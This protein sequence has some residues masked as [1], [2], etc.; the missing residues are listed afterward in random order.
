MIKILNASQTRAL[1]A[2]TIKHEPV[3][4]LDLMERA[5][6]EFTEW[7][8]TH[9]RIDNKIAV[10]CGT[11]NNGGDGLGIA[12]LLK[13]RGY[14]VRVFIVKGGKESDDFKQNQLRLPE[15]IS[16]R[17]IIDHCNDDFADTDVLIDAIFGS[18]L[19][20]PVEGVYADVIN[21]INAS[22]AVKIA[23][24]IPSGLMADKPSSGTI[25]KASYTITFQLPKLAMFM[26]GNFSFTGEWVVVNIGLDRSFIKETPTPYYYIQSKD[27]RRLLRQRTRFDHKGTFGHAL[28][29]AGSHGKMGAAI[30]ATR[31]ALRSGAGLVSAH[32]PGCGYEIMQV[33]APEAMVHVDA[34]DLTIASVVLHENVNAV[35]IGPGLGQDKQTLVALR[36]LLEQSRPMV[37]D[38]DALNLIAANRELLQ[39]IPRNSILTPHPKEFARLAGETSNGF[40]RIERAR[41][42]AKEINCFIVLKGAFTAIV[43]PDR[44]VFFN[45]TGNPGMATGGSGD[46]LT[47][48][49]CGLLAQGYEPQNCCLLGVYLHGL[50]GDLAADDKGMEAMIAGDLIE[51]LPAAYKKLNRL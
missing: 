37:I 41:K 48:I 42:F 5:C 39:I 21:R 34:S 45:S 33:A 16:V 38:A 35:G 43:T 10:V 17:E 24:D 1:D 20:R 22:E 4:S 47:G 18:G 8:T 2:Y 28:I 15:S 3:S 13:D 29:V 14:P 7:F 25:V 26:P 40:D 49:L 50:A 19:T 46:V 9:V 23:V 27:A 32:V 12:R 11:G 31:A 51:F 6:E 44:N 36:K 30:L